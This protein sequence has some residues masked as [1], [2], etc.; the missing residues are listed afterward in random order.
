[1]LQRFK[2]S[3]AVFQRGMYM[4]LEGLIGKT[5]FVYIDDILVFGRESEEHNKNLSE[6][7][8][9]LATYGLKINDKKSVINRE[10][11]DFLGYSI[12]ENNVS[13]TL[14]KS[15]AIT[16]YKTLTNKREVRRFLNMA[17]YDRSFIPKLSELAK[18]LYNIIVAKVFN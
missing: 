8:K 3:P 13:P 9:R 18:P 16:R 4:V 7:K 12:S 2:N 17:N 14:N 10:K 6:V 5:C 15:E 11:V 1:M